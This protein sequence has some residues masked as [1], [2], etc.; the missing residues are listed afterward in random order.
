M[1]TRYTDIKLVI[2]VLLNKAHDNM[3]FLDVLAQQQQ[4][5]QHRAN[6]DS[7]NS[8]QQTSASRSA[9]LSLLV[10]QQQAVNMEHSDSISL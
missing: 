3:S 1:S 5:Q 6:A 2:P 8:Q 7:K 10:K 9:V 4:Q